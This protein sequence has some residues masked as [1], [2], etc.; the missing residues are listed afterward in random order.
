MSAPG[1]GSLLLGVQF[2]PALIPYTPARLQQDLD[3]GVAGILAGVGSDYR[4]WV[5][6]DGAQIQLGHKD[7]V[8]GGYSAA[9]DAAN[10]RR[11]GLAITSA[12]IAMGFNDIDGAWHN[13]IAL[14]AA[15]GS[16]TFAGTVNATAGNFASG[17]TIGGTSITL[18]DLAAGSYTAADLQSDLEAGV[19]TILA[20]VGGNYRMWIDTAG[21]QIQMGHKDLN[22][23]GLGASYSGTLRSGVAITS[24]GIAMGYNRYSDGAWVNAVAI[25][26]GGD[27]TISGTL[28]AGSV[29]HPGVSL[30]SGS[31]LGT[32]ASQASSAYTATQSLG[33][34]AT[35]NAVNLATQVT[36]QLTT[37]NITGLG[38]LAVLNSINLGTQT[39][40]QINLATQVT[41][42]L[43]GATQ[44]TNLGALAYANSLAANLI[45]A[46][47]LAAGVIYSGS[48]YASQIT[49]GTLTAATVDT[50][51]YIRAYGNYSGGI[52]LLSTTYYPTV[53]GQNN[54]GTFGWGVLGYG[55]SGSGGG[56]VFGYSAAADGVYGYAASTSG[57]GVSGKGNGVGVRGESFGA[58]YAGVVAVNGAGGPALTV[59]GRMT[60]S[61]NTLV[62]NLNADLLD[63]YDSSAFVRI[64]SGRTNN[65]YIYSIDVNV[66]APSNGTTRAGWIKIA[67]NGG[68]GVWVPYYT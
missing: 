22:R 62:S 24:S 42:L 5:D 63:G 65:D 7:V 44:I 1:I 15:T 61:S 59:S 68:G 23:G 34:L 2:A 64:A 36:G 6:T 19:G 26:A 57:V 60:I 18:G 33:A 58:S 21:A 55:S 41:G 3:S 10:A 13:S 45:G 35:Q 25:S 48:I 49:T 29:I 66:T 52:N 38:A 8:Y 56:G 37:S 16:A 11:P 31:T 9:A 50:S 43:N 4:L 20:G 40:G 30:I 12:G 53:F 27:V 54:Y 17:I 28:S 46:G 32:I 39:S 67:N 51:S 47:T 14:D